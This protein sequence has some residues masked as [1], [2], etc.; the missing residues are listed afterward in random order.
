MFDENYSKWK[1]WANKGGGDSFGA[2]TTYES[3]Y[4]KRLLKLC[5]VSK[6]SNILEVGFGN[7]GFLSF[8]RS[9]G[10]KIRGTEANLAL[11]EIAHKH[12]FEVGIADELQRL[13]I[14]SF[15]SIISLDVIEHIDPSE[16]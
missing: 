4:Y 10:I 15:D 11:V 3:S 1:N 5:S 12:G 16:T 14:E 2:F 6:D 9:N 13:P 7:G 8:C